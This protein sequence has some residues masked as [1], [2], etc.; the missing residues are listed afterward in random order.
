MSGGRDYNCEAYNAMV[1]TCP[2]PLNFLDM[3]HLLQTNNLFGKN[4][5][6]SFRELKDACINCRILYK[7]E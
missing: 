3:D 5:N 4:K 7:T 2:F 6:G 1:K